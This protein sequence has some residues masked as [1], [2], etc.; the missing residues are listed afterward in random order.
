MKEE[1]NYGT[2]TWTGWNHGDATDQPYAATSSP[3]E[4]KPLELS[5]FV[6]SDKRLD[7]YHL[8]FSSRL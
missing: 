7:N 5:E 2:S 6:T 3:A 4:N 8:H 1:Q